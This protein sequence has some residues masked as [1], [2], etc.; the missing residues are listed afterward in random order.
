MLND[1]DSPSQP[2]HH[3]NVKE[4]L[5][6][7][8]IELIEKDDMAT[9]S[10]RR[11]SREVGVTPSAV[12]NHFADKDALLLAIK[13]RIY[14][15]MNHFFAVHR[16][17]TDDPEQELLEICLAYYHYSNEYTAQFQF[18]F[19]S[20]LP[21][22]WS[23]PEAVA[24]SCRSLLHVRRLVWEIYAKYRVSCSETEVVNAALLVWSQVHGIVT[25][26][27]SGSI[28]AAVAHLQWPPSCG[29]THD[30]EVEQLIRSHLQS[31]VNGILNNQH[32]GS[33]H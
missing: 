6:S 1:D 12:Y 3:G 14:D 31:M 16:S 19:S 5:V 17:G 10:L 28:K 18:L 8:A 27:S 21:L 9:L 20:T 26:R 33:H 32:G 2:Y 7:V 23:T 11:L 25:L 29:L 13:T 22:E 4:A 30:T 24:V 15:H